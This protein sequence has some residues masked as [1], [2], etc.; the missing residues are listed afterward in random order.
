VLFVWR[1]A[2][3]TVVTRGDLPRAR[4]LARSVA[5]HHDGVDTYVLV[6]D[7][8]ARNTSNEPECHVLHLVDVGLG[9]QSG[10][11]MAVFARSLS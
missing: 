8:R 2:V 5:R 3:C 9:G 4:V 6:V 11:I 10:E 1:F 7:D